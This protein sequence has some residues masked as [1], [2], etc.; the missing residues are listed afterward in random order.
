MSKHR[1]RLRYSSKYDLGLVLMKKTLLAL[2][3]SAESLGVD[4][5]DSDRF[6]R[7]LIAKLIVPSPGLAWRLCASCGV[8]GLLCAPIGP[9]SSVGH[10]VTHLYLHICV[11][12]REKQEFE[13]PRFFN[14]PTGGISFS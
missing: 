6:S 8:T 14:I 2:V 11:T 5:G 13:T 10:V 12:D 9:L 7:S 4:G 1:D 3:V